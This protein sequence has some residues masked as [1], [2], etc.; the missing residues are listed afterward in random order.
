M[1]W[2]VVGSTGLIGKHLCRHLA[3][4]GD[5]VV[6]VSRSGAS[7]P[8]AQARAWD[9]ADGPIPPAH[10]QGA[11]VV[12]NL[13][14]AGIGD[15]RWT[16][17]RKRLIVES[18]VAATDGIVASLGDPDTPGVLV[19]AS[20]VGVYG[21]G[22][23]V[24]TEQSPLGDDFLATTCARWEQAA[25]AATDKGVRVALT[26]FGIVLAPDGGALSKQLLP[27]RMGVGGPL[28]GGRQWM[29]WVHIAD[30]VGLIVL[31]ATDDGVAGP[32]NVVAPGPVRQREFAKALGRALGRPAVVPTPGFVLRAA[33]GEM[34]TLVLDGQRVVPEVAVGQGYA[35]THPDLDAALRDVVAG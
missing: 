5:T 15:A 34:A 9:P 14:G 29:S 13:A 21:T 32:V 10:L 16:D 3:D 12:V 25:E 17:E 1:K 6:A 18:R 8:G 28:G 4:R 33:M 26:R 27:F 22:E 35:F 20:A 30:A 31:A 7:V 2:V 19:N 24:C 11:D 23:R